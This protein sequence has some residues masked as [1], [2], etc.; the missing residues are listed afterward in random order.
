MNNKLLE[1]VTAIFGMSMD[2]LD[3]P[4]FKF[5]IIFTRDAD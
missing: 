3:N 4:G 5:V 2:D 1:I